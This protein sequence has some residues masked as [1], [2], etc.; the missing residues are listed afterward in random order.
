MQ[1]SQST[2]P[3]SK[4]CTV[5]I[6]GEKVCVHDGTWKECEVSYAFCTLRAPANIDIQKGHTV[7]DF[8]KQID[9]VYDFLNGD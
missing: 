1:Y 8:V 5:V 3:Q 6:N 7:S 2:N 9:D 4:S